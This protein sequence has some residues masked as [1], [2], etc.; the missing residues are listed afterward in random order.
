[1][2]LYNNLKILII[3]FVMYNMI[4]KLYLHKTNA[5]KIQQRTN[6]IAIGKNV[7]EI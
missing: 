2:E 4:I 3:F 5:G 7:R 1:M 6:S